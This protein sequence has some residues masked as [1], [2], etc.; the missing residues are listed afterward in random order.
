MDTSYCAVPP[1][2]SAACCNRHLGMWCKICDSSRRLLFPSNTGST[3]DGF[4]AKLTQQGGQQNTN[5]SKRHEQHTLPRGWGMFLE[6][7]LLTTFSNVT[8]NLLHHGADASFALFDTKLLGYESKRRTT[9]VDVVILIRFS[10]SSSL[11]GIGSL[12]MYLC[13]ASS[14]TGGIL[15]SA[16]CCCCCCC[17]LVVATRWCGGVVF[18]I[19]TIRN[20]VSIF[21]GSFVLTIA[22]FCCTFYACLSTTCTVRS[23]QHFDPSQRSRTCP[24]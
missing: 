6:D 13:A 17:C 18:E 12:S 2:P 11:S 20:V 3:R 1:P 8:L 4:F 19:Q 16:C 5:E 9:H 21:I 23:R 10:C 22:F 24:F 15:S 14:D 7:E